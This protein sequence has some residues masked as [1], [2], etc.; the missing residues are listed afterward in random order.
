M[1]T[2]FEPSQP[3]DCWL[4]CR[5]GARVG[6]SGLELGSALGFGIV[7]HLLHG[8]LAFVDRKRHLRIGLVVGC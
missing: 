2:K 3:L 5:L 1:S 8:R 4:E 7:R 6:V